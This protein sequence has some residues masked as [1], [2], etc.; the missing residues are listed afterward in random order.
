MY[1]L[2]VSDNNNSLEHGPFKSR[3][4]VMAER[5]KLIAA[6]NYNAAHGFARTTYDDTVVFRHAIYSTVVLEITEQ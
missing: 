4:D 1:T 2:K 6:Y 5:G 3:R